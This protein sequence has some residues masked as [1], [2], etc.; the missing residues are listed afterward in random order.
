MVMDTV[1]LLWHSH[2]TG[3]GELNEKI[4]GVHRSKEEANAA[5]ERAL[6]R[7]GFC[8]YP[9]GFK[10]TSAIVGKDYWEHGYFT[11]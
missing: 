2:P 6:L 3:A 8:D 4:I 10:I 1:Y 9:E 5:I 7:P 11:E